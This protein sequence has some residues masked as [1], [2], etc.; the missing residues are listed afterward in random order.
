MSGN[1]RQRAA[2]VVS[3]PLRAQSAG[4]LNADLFLLLPLLPAHRQPTLRL[5]V[6]Y[7]R[8]TNYAFAHRRSNDRQR[9]GLRLI[10]NIT[11]L[12]HAY[13]RQRAANGICRNLPPEMGMNISCFIY[14]CA[15]CWRLGN[16]VVHGVPSGISFPNVVF[17]RTCFAFSEF[18]QRNNSLF[19]HV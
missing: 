7:F 11:M 9:A 17:E 1:F 13:N 8:T 5:N 3:R 6:N 18:E 16:Y 15:C 14:L 2:K 12:M 10:E 4:R 19:S